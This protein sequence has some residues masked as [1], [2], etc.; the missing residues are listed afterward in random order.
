[1]KKLKGKNALLTG[2]SMGIGPNIARV[3]AREGVNIALSARS[4]DKLKA[5]AEELTE[6]NVRAI[7]VPADVTDP[8][9]REKMVEKVKSEFGQIDLLIN[10]AGIEWLSSFNDL[11]Q[12]EIENMIQT[13]LIAPLMITRLVLPE[14]L[15]RS[16]GHVVTISSLGGKKG[17]PYSA[18]YAATKAGLIA[19][20]SSLRA[21]LYKTGVSASVVCPGFISDTGMFAVYNKKAPKIAGESKPEAVYKAV[22]KCI[23]KD[24]QEIVV[25]PG[26]TRLML[27]IDAI[28][29]NIITSILRKTGVH[30]FFRLQALDN[31]NNSNAR[32]IK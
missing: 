25:N 11:T 4:E 16:S 29:P 30:E 1:M 5:V 21:E 22:L 15:K 32:G 17:S 20:T 19:W 3:L 9:S 13:N 18:T 31:K 7:A 14:M 12:K 10:N 24:I 6:Y 26:A 23:K 8:D 28:N 2:G 27:M